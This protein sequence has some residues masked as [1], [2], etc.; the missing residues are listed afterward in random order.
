MKM[1]KKKNLKSISV[2]D[3]VQS[4]DCKSGSPSKIFTCIDSV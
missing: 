4:V 1:Y 3:V 2:K